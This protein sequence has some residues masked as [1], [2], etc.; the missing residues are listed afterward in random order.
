MTWLSLYG[1]T[2]TSGLYKHYIRDC[3]FIGRGE[4]GGK[5]DEGIGENHDVTEGVRC[6]ILYVRRGGGKAFLFF[7]PFHKLEKG[8]KSY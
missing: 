7:I 5:P 4:G 2:N 3:L 1:N 6:K 8:K